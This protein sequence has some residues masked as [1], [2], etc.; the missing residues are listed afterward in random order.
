MHNSTPTVSSTWRVTALHRCSVAAY[1]S[2]VAIVTVVQNG[3][4]HLIHLLH[5]DRYYPLSLSIRHSVRRII[6]AKY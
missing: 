6:L 3:V 4:N 1:T 5:Y 2:N